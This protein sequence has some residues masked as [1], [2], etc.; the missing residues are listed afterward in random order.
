MPRNTVGGG[1]SNAWEQPESQ[2]AQETPVFDA[3]L[4]AV[5]PDEEPAGTVTG[6]YSTYTVRDLVRECQERGISY[7]GQSGTLP[8][9]DLIARLSGQ[10]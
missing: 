7:S 9:A 6:D 8:K 1:Y 4:A 2:S 10:E 5:Q 3:W